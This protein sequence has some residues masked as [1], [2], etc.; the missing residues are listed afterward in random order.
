M[1]LKILLNIN[2]SIPFLDLFIRI[3]SNK[4]ILSIYR[5]PT[6]TDHVIPYNSNHPIK[7]KLAAFHSFFHRLLS[8]PLND[9]DF[10]TEYHTILKIASN[11]NFPLALI[12]NIFN[13]KLF[14]K[15]VNKYTSL[16]P[17][18]NKPINYFSIPYIE[19]ISPKIKR[20]FSKQNI[21]I[22]FKQSFSLKSAL[23]HTKD[24]INI[25]QRS[26]IYKLTCSCNKFYIGRSFR[27]LE[28]RLGEHRKQYSQIYDVNHPPKSA[29]SKHVLFN[30]HTYPDSAEI[31]FTTENN[32]ICDIFEQLCIIENKNH[33]PNFLLNEQTDFSNIHI[34][35]H[36]LN[37]NSYNLQ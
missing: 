23:C 16:I 9:I 28:V 11:N 17:N 8:V 34:F 37:N 18:I 32:Y 19:H 29:F 30:N 35:Q 5:K 33:S 26:G 15:N 10:R 13:K 1:I 12:E 22:S 3:S 25:L 21:S 36:F 2:N 31:L 14:S 6:T 7:H 4:I 27:S 20:F 24:P